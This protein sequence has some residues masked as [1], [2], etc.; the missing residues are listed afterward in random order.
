MSSD[1]PLIAVTT[2]RRLLAT[3]LG[4]RTELITLA[5]EYCAAVR[6]AGGIPVLVADPD[7]GEAARLLDTA[8]GLLLSGGGDVD[9]MAYGRVATAS[10]GVDPRRDAAESALVAAARERKL[11]L[12]GICRGMQILNVACGGSCIED[13]P[14]TSS[15]QRPNDPAARL[16]LR[17]R[18]TAS[19]TW[20]LA[21]LA[22]DSTGAGVV[23]SIHH[24]AV[25]RIGA[26]LR[27]VALAD[28]GVVEA[29]E[30][31]DPS[32]FV[33]AVQ[34]HPEKMRSPAEIAHPSAILE[35]FISAATNYRA[36]KNVVDQE[37]A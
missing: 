28:D 6:A 1:S 22:R 37:S 35:D 26:G 15:H 12:F 18:V 3:D 25:D 31:A 21:G 4:D 5:A 23:N 17:H 14:S 19:A 7:P 27:A 29:V 16:A 13:L 33:R 9:P 20:P 2:W 8:D 32:W 24:Q 30:G 34:W 10:V 11:P 36:H